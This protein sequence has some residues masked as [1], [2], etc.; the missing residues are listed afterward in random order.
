MSGND[1]QCFDWTTLFTLSNSPL[2][3]TIN[4]HNSQHRKQTSPWIIMIFWYPP[5]EKPEDDLDIIYNLLPSEE[6]FHMKIEMCL[7]KSLIVTYLSFTG[8]PRLFLLSNDWTVLKTRHNWWHIIIF[9]H[10]NEC[11]KCPQVGIINVL[12][13]L[14]HC[15]HNDVGITTCPMSRF[16]ASFCA[17]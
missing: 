3:P 5:F 8:L 12:S 4:R 1:L 6:N 7:D 14:P 9:Q 17:W 16:M 13:Q 15:S 11:H 2:P 10:T